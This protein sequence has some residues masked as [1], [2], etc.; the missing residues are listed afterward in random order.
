M[1][2]LTRALLV[3]DGNYVRKWYSHLAED[4][5]EGNYYSINFGALV[6]YIGTVIEKDFGNR[7]AFVAKKLY[8]GTNSKV[9]VLNQDFYRALDVG[10]IQKNT[11]PLRTQDEKGRAALKEEACDTTIVFNTTKE[12]YLTARENRFDTLVLFAGDGD[13]TPLVEGLKSEG[14]KSI[15]VYYDFRSCFNTTRASQKLLESADKV[16][17]FGAFLVER[18]NKQ[19]MSILEPL[20]KPLGSGV[21]TIL[22]DSP[23]KN[24][25]VVVKKRNTEF[26][27]NSYRTPVC[28]LYTK[29]E[30]EKA[31]REIPRRDE[32][33]WVLVAL[34]G[35][36][37]ES[38][39][40]KVLPM[41][42]KLKDLLILYG[43]IFETKEVPAYSV[44]IRRQIK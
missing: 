31:V 4:G 2:R 25:T 13:L 40:G 36:Y 20:E 39:T 10:G 11:F 24:R 16:I 3:M 21:S 27:M 37:L 26:M 14:V 38:T 19:V 6:D 18:V 30:L 8:M 35:K 44:R 22:Y 29:E 23:T 43:N 12:F 42:T 7:C 34:L 1:E 17:N 32:E 5:I 28:E 41:G 15:V 9:D 33:G